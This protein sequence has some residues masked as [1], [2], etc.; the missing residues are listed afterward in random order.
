MYRATIRDSL[1]VK[2]GKRLVDEWKEKF[3]FLTR[4]GF[5][6]QEIKVVK[7]NPAIY[8]YSFKKNNCTVSI[9]L[10]PYN[11]N[12]SIYWISLDIDLLDENKLLKDSN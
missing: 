7:W 1:K 10:F 11:E 12:S 2:N 8:G 5:N 9:C 4:S 3:N 6:V